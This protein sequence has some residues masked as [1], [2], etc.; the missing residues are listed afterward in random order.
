MDVLQNEA[1]MIKVNQEL[2]DAK[3]K[4]LATQTAA[5]VN[6]VAMP[7]QLQMLKKEHQNRAQT[8]KNSNLQK[9][10]EKYGGEK[11]LEV[12]ESMKATI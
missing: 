3:G 8:M 7:S 11:H 2:T 5:E 10:L 4:N 1:F 9:L 12:S 6:A